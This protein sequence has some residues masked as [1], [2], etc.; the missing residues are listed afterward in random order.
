[1]TTLTVKLHGFLGKKY[2]KSVAL[3]GANMFQIM[4]GL[5]S[6]FG[7][8]FKEDIRQH[9]W[10]VCEGKVAP[11]N[12]IGQ[13][14]LDKPLTKKVLHL[15]PAVAGSSAAVRIIIGVA[16]ILYGTF[17]AAYGGGPWATNMGIAL[18]MGGVVEMLTRPKTQTPV[19]AQDQRGSSIYNGALNVTTQG[20]PVPLV[21]GRV[22][23]ASSV[24]ISTDFSSDEA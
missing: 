21:Y 20:G 24:V 14:E 16:L 15:V 9:N 8:E 7:P 2:A 1:M 11:E 10:H 12:D 3:S 4:S 19:Q 23:R 22:Q 5:V 18:V 17:G 13:N 6:R